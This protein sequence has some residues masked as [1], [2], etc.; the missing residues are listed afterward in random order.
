MS[1]YSKSMFDI[2]IERQQILQIKVQERTHQNDGSI[3]LHES[4]YLYLSLGTRLSSGN[5][6]TYHYDVQLLEYREH[7][8]IKT[9]FAGHIY[10]DDLPELIEETLKKYSKTKLLEQDE[11]LATNKCF[12]IV[13]LLDIQKM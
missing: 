4:K 13:N 11:M 12:R 6:R 10:F 8:G 2:M 1:F 7:L 9:L 5:N 3:Y